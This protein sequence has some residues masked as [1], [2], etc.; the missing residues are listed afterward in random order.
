MG[1][2]QSTPVHTASGPRRVNWWQALRLGSV[3]AAVAAL[4][5]FRFALLAI[6][7]TQENDR[8]R[9]GSRRDQSGREPNEKGFVAGLSPETRR[10]LVSLIDYQLTPVLVDQWR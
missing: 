1:Q 9:Q 6:E 2:E 4:Q 8:R 10:A 3:T 7:D 5:W